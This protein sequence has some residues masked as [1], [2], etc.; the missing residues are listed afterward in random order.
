MFNQ[1]ITRFLIACLAFSLFACTAHSPAEKMNHEEALVSKIL[2]KEQQDKL[3][4]DD[5][6]RLL[7]EGNRRFVANQ[8]TNR[9]HSELVRH[10]AMGQYPKAIVLS[11]IDSRVPV[12]DVFELGIGDIFVARVAGNFE[13]TDILGSME[14]ASKVAGAKLVLVLGHERCGA[15]KGAV[16]N[17]QI[18]NIKP[19]LDNI[20]P[21]IDHFSE[22]HG[23]KT[24]KNEEFV[25]MVAEQNVWNT[26][27]DIRKGSPIL[28]AMEQAGEIKIVGAIYDMDTGEVTFFK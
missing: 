15:I 18:G 1:V 24:S 20:K 12:E 9:D 19:M 10:A 25:H 17:V 8:Y 22:Y 16:D 28:S 13:N 21:A 11:C 23:V 2:T 6:I 27:D 14:F 26:I 7:K 4:P 5:V 3:T